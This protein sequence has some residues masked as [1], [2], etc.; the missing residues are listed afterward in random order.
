MLSPRALAVLYDL[1]LAAIWRGDAP[2]SILGDWL[3]ARWCT[4]SP[5]EPE[6]T[7][8][9]VSILEGAGAGSRWYSAG[10][11]VVGF[12]S[13]RPHGCFVIAR[14]LRPP[15]PPN[16]EFHGVAELTRMPE[17]VL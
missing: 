13:G 12:V 6:V 4:G 14:E 7:P 10:E 15:Q 3:E 2:P 5:S 17:T 8:D 9:A 1:H 16:P 11:T